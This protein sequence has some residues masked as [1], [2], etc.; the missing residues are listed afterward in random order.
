MEE[1]YKEFGE[2]LRNMRLSLDWQPKVMGEALGVHRTTL[3][4]WEKGEKL[5]NRDIYELELQIRDIVKKEI[6]KRKQLVG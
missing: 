3:A 1:E 5:V 6:Q 2:F 4:R